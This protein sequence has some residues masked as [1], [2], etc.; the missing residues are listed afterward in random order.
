MD[1]GRDQ[2][3]AEEGTTYVTAPVEEEG[4]LRKRHGYGRATEKLRG[5]SMAVQAGGRRTLGGDDRQDSAVE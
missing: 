4:E 1:Q 2:G 5:K 3:G